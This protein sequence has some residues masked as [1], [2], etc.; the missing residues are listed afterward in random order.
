MLT[1][2]L[3]VSIVCASIIGV[4]WL[5]RADERKRAGMRPRRVTAMTL[6]QERTGRPCKSDPLGQREDPVLAQWTMRDEEQEARNQ[7]S[8]RRFDE[9]RR[10]RL[11]PRWP[12]MVK[13][14]LEG[15]PFLRLYGG[16]AVIPWGE[17]RQPRHQPVALPHHHNET[18][19]LK[20]DWNKP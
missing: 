18:L 15:V 11:D 13:R 19:T 1:A 16:Y 9:H 4:D 5:Q 12:V 14:G 2:A 20:V 8:A 17:G 3:F 10:A 7:A 6:R